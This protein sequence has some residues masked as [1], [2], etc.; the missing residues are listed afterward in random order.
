MIMD[1]Q[2]ADEYY[3]TIHMICLIMQITI[4]NDDNSEKICD[5]ISV[6]DC[7]LF[8]FLALRFPR[9]IL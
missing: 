6:I 4:S 1:Y 2:F 9:H 8:A 3:F 7:N 5:M